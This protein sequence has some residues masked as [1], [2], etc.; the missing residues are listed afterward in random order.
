MRFFA[1]GG[2]AM[3]TKKQLLNQVEI[4]KLQN[5]LY[6]EEISSLRRVNADLTAAS[7]SKSDRIDKLFRELGKSN[8]EFDAYKVGAQTFQKLSEEQ[9]IKEAAE[10]TILKL[11]LLNSLAATVY[12]EAKKDNG[13]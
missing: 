7:A 9:I 1:R 13:V 2:K 5:S 12:G 6:L 3:Q 11:N 10:V 4:L 8:S